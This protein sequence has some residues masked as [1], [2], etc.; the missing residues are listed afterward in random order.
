M[1]AAIF[2]G[3]PPGDRQAVSSIWRFRPTGSLAVSSFLLAHCGGGQDKPG[4]L[5]PSAEY[6]GSTFPFVFLPQFLLRSSLP[7]F[8]SRFFFA[9]ISST[10][11]FPTFSGAFRVSPQG[12]GAR[13]KVTYLAAL[14]LGAGDFHRLLVDHCGYRSARHSAQRK[15]PRVRGVVCKEIA[16]GKRIRGL[17]C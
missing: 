16:R 17:L 10:K 3:C 2:R 4:F 9:S 7:L 13:D 14:Y 1:P 12:C 5:G 15:E 6:P 8:C 11:L